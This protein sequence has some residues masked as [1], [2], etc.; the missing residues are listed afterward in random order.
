MYAQYLTNGKQLNF[1]KPQVMGIINLTPDSFFDG[2]KY[3]SINAILK[4]VEQKITEGATIIDIGAASSKQNAIQLTAKEE[5][6]RLKGPLNKIREEFPNT[7]ISVDTYWSEVA[8]YVINN[9]ADVINDISAGEIDKYLLSTVAKYDVPYIMMH[10]QGTPQNMQNNPSY[11]N[12]VTEVLDF[13]TK[14][15][16]VCKQLGIEKTI[17]DVGFG[18]GKTIEHNYQL[19][20]NLSSFTSLKKPLLVGLSRKSMIYKLLNT[21]PQY[22]LN[23]TTV[24]NTLALQQGVN[25]LRVHDVKE[26]K[27]AIDLIDFSNTM[28]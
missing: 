13:F 4:D 16:E 15:I 5:I 12:V 18:F 10:M 7:I 6:E 11:E 22:A 8:E 17:I 1:E 19:L 2:G 24:L 25:I 21:T 9:G 27:E 14:K 3:N 23:G 20:T 28:G 26:A